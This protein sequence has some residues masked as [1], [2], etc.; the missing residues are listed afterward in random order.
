[1]EILQAVTVLQPFAT[2]IVHGGRG[3]AGFKDVEN[4]NWYCNHRGI[5]LIHAGKGDRYLKYR[6]DEEDYDVYRE[7][8]DGLPDMDD[9]PLG[10][11]VGAVEMV[12]CY[13]AGSKKRSRW[14]EGKWCWRFVKPIAFDNPVAVRGQ[15]GLWILSEEV[16]ESCHEQLKGK[17]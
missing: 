13:K 11:I 10:V 15:Q 8:H 5:L 16:M 17:A 2:L 9:L 7:E 1:M 12:D 6:E 14:E 4:R 3:W